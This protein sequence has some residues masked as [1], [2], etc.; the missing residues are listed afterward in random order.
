MKA[1]IVVEDKMMNFKD[2]K[3]AEGMDIHANINETN[4]MITGLI[5]CF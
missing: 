1:G 2:L 3:K 5:K 4:K